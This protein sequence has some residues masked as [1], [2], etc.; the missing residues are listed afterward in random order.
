MNTLTTRGLC[1]ILGL[2]L[3]AATACSSKKAATNTQ[4]PPTVTDTAT[5]SAPSPT[6]TTAAPTQAAS[7][8]T[9]ASPTRKASPIPTKAATGPTTAAPTKLAGQTV[10]QPKLGAYTYALSGSSQS[11]V[12]GLPQSYPAGAVLTVEYFEKNAQGGG[13][14]YGARASTQQDQ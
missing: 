10:N 3:L 14:E 9:S 7:P 4:S 2:G 12:L 5:S 13:I 6:A 8:A 11:P 1:L